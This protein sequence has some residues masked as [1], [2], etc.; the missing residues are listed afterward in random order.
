MLGRFQL[1]LAEN[2]HAEGARDGCKPTQP[3]NAPRAH[4]LTAQ[5]YPTLAMTR[6]SFYPRVTARTHR[7]DGDFMSTVAARR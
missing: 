6:Q 2:T 4:C 3:S 5:K 1:H 7:D